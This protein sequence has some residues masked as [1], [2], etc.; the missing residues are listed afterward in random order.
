M[1]RG[2]W[3]GVVRTTDIPVAK[4]SHRLARLSNEPEKWMPRWPAKKVSE[5]DDFSDRQD[6][7]DTNTRR[8]HTLTLG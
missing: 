3:A 6:T 1:R 7:A 2:K 5:I 4:T 8:D